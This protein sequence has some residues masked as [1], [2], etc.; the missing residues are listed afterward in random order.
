MNY[1]PYMHIERLGN[2]EV[3]GIDEG[4]CYIFPKIDGTNGVIYF[5]D[6][7]IKFGSRRNPLDD[8]DNQGFRRDVE[9]D[10]PLMNRLGTYFTDFPETIL[11]GEWLVPHTFKDYRT[12]AWRR[13][14]IFDVQDKGKLLH[15]EVYSRWLFQYSLL[16]IPPQNILLNPAAKDFLFELD[17]NFY[18]VQ[19]GK[20]P[21]EGIVIKNYGFTNKYGKQIWAKMVRNEFKDDHRTTMGVTPRECGAFE[22]RI[23]ED[24]VDVLGLILGKVR[25]NIIVE[26]EGWRSQYIPELL[27]RVYHDFVVEEIWDI[28]KTFK[29]PVIDFRQLQKHV[30]AAIKTAEPKLF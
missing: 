27:G 2:E 28:L 24:N 26:R 18:L 17:K 30:I 8:H 3:E 20:G 23:L 22:A 29:H 11:Y 1:E 14:Y 5:Q 10:N 21:G 25:T 4:T 9:A 16:A 7:K 13:F 12:D 6:G 15:Y 19:D